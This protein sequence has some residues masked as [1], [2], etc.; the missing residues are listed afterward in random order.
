MLF[1]RGRFHADD[2]LCRFDCPRGDIRCNRIGIEERLRCKA[3][4]KK[5]NRPDLGDDNAVKAGLNY[6]GACIQGGPPNGK[7]PMRAF[8]NFLTGNLYF[9]WSLERVGVIYGLTTIGKQDWYE[10]GADAL[11]NSQMADG[12]WNAIG[13]P[14][15]SPEITHRSLFCF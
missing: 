1:R 15:A 8:N 4:A 7:M 2:D 14:G 5:D 10:F 3:P 12:S 13:Y 6:L 11:V 9:L